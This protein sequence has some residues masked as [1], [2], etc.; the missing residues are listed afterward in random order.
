MIRGSGGANEQLLHAVVVVAFDRATGDVHGTYVHGSLHRPDPLGA[1]LGGERLLEEIAARMGETGGVVDL[2]ELPLD[3]VPP[4][5][6]A[7]VDPQTRRVEATADAT[8]S[9]SRLD[10]P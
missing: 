7:R 10:R 6:I 2:I 1:R 8:A 3:E 4:T 9:A 5:G